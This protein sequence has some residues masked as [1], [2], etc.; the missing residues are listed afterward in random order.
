[1]KGTQVQR[2][3]QRSSKEAMEVYNPQRTIIWVVYRLH[4]KI[5]SNFGEGRR[6]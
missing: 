3:E 4:G 6:F 2:N 1:M 5:F